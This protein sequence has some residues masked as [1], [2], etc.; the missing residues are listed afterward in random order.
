MHARSSFCDAGRLRWL[1]VAAMSLCATSTRAS[2]LDQLLLKEDNAGASALADDQVLHA[3]AAGPAHG[4]ERADA[5]EQR[6]WVAFIAGEISRPS[7]ADDLNRALA[8]READ[9]HPGALG[10]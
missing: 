8:L 3:E 6:A 7:I 1:F 10:P 4:A 2:N 9:R 5:L